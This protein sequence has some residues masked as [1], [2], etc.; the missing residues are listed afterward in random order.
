MEDFTKGLVEKIGLPD[1]RLMEAMQREHCT[2]QTPHPTPQ[3]LNPKP[4][5]PNPKP[6][7][8]NP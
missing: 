5:T 8:L 1:P 3:T 2:P 7:T 4:Q 6:Q